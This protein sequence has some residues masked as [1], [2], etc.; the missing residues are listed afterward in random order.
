MN[1]FFAGA[2][3]MTRILRENKAEN[4]LATYYYLRHKGEKKVEQLLSTFPRVFLDSGAFSFREHMKANNVRPDEMEHELQGYLRQYKEFLREYG[5]RF[6]IC[7]ELD[8]GD[9]YQKTKNREKLLD[10]GLTNLL[11][12]IHKRDSRA[13]IEFLCKTYPYVAIGSVPDV[14]FNF[15][16][17]YIGARMR[18]GAKYGTKFHGFA[19][20]NIE[21]LKRFPLY[22]ADS[23]TWLSGAKHGMSFWF[24]G[25]KL[26]SYDKFG[27]FHR[28]RWKN[29]VIEAG[30]NWD[31]FIG[32]KAEAVNQ[33][34]LK[35]WIKFA[36]WMNDPVNGI[37]QFKEKS[38]YFRWREHSSTPYERGIW[39]PGEE[40]YDGYSQFV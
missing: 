19:I 18:I 32:D 14:S 21:V 16:C 40:E 6:F 38:E 33:F 36:N 9:M 31:A 34:S 37:G 25:H 15:L 27:K 5:H 13:Y 17:R 4:V 30:V 11:P 12:V 23:T 29:M 28:M 22:S 39:L 35:Q 24:D 2:E 20:T 3:S 26:R 7:A 8:V 1:L 10:L